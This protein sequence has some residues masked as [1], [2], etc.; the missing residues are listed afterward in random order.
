MTP[1]PGIVVPKQVKWRYP[2]LV[3]GL[4]TTYASN[5][6]LLGFRDRTIARAGGWETTNKAYRW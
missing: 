4:P 1:Y 3:C 6:T 5:S 2:N